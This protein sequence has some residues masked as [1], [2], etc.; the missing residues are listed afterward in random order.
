LIPLGLE[1]VVLFWAISIA[2]AHLIPSFV[3][4]ISM[5]LCLTYETLISPMVSVAIAFGFLAT[6]LRV[7]G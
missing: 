7:E 1:I 5:V 3:L 6:L 2:L 4:E